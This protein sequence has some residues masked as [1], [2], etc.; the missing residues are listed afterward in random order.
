MKS[1]SAPHLAYFVLIDVCSALAGR[2]AAVT[3]V[4]VCA[5]HL[6]SRVGSSP[7]HYP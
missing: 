6:P 5:V 1:E 7:R 3:C 4:C 2:Y